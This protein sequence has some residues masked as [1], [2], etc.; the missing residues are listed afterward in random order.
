MAERAAEAEAFPFGEAAGRRRRGL[1]LPNGPLLLGALLVL[2]VL[3]LA[4]RGPALAP[5]D[6]LESNPTQRVGDVWLSPPFPPLTVPGFPLGSDQLGRDVLSQL[7]WAIRPT[8]TL[9]VLVAA[10]RLLLGTLIG[11]VAG[12]A[13]GRVGQAAQ[14]L[15]ASALSVPVLFVALAVIAAVGIEQG[16][17]AFVLALAL[18]GWG[19]SASVVR[20]QTQVLK[21]QT[22]IEAAR[23]L[24]EG[25]VGIVTRHIL[26]QIVPLLW[27]LFA[28]EI[29]STLVIVAALGFLGYYL[30]G[31]TWVAVSDTVA[32][33]FSGT[34]ELG[35]MLA[36]TIGQ[37][38][39]G[40]W[41]AFAA[42]SMVFLIVLGFNLLTEGLRLR[43]NSGHSR[44][45]LVGRAWGWVSAQMGERIGEPLYARFGRRTVRVTVALA[46]LF[47]LLVGYGG[48]GRGA[49]SAAAL[50]VPGD[51]PWATER[52]D[53]FGTLWSAALG[54]KIP[55][56]QARFTDASGFVGGPVISADGALYLAARNQT[57]YAL[58]AERIGA[59]P[60]WSAALPEVPVGS[61]ALDA[62][63]RIFVA[64]EGGGLVAFSPEGELLWHT[65]PEGS[66][67]ATS[68]PIVAPDGRLFY[69]VAGTLR[70]LSPEGKIVWQ[71]LLL[72]APHVQPPHLSP[73]GSLLLWGKR[74]VLA[75]SGEDPTAQVPQGGT[76]YAVGADGRLY[77][78]VQHGSGFI[79]LTQWDF[80]AP[81]E[82]H[83]VR[84]I[85]WAD[86]R[87]FVSPP[88]QMGATPNSVLWFAFSF[89]KIEDA[90]LAWTDLDGHALPVASF[91]H[92]PTRPLAVDGA[93]V[94]YTCGSNRESGPECLAFSPGSEQPRWQFPLPDA[95]TIVGGALSERGLYVSTDAGHLYLIGEK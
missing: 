68:G 66:L 20:Q 50:L 58:E 63:G 91:P 31:E 60:R 65:Q 22:Y 39:H 90:K 35:Q 69:A 81:G 74:I 42:G 67:P 70:A 27:M 82:A 11:A 92:R 2:L 3:L 26:R 95:G 80:V 79:G 24:G 88:Q 75:A 56:L 23:A 84:E 94:L 47:A 44:P 9:V 51:H 38:Y 13:R 53:P 76:E 87:R 85:G 46:L 57:L 6:P 59:A 1:R 33:R 93:N 36:G 7:L 89:E 54:P 32:Q 30:G 17:R 86:A 48:R 73:D 55:T 28:Y 12:W 25:S 4:W 45:T 29:S 19:E 83:V 37:L 15:L 40:P 34:P 16:T 72:D 78:R 64:G 62:A 52:H 43:L 61:P 49:G 5:R 8:M 18:T 10:L 77:V 21:G 41:R 71:R 14:V